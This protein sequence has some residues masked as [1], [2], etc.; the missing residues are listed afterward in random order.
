MKRT[1]KIASMAVAAMMLLSTPASAQFGGLLKKAK[2]SLGVSVGSDS[3]DDDSS[4][5]ESSVSIP[6]S[7]KKLDKEAFIYQP[8]DDPVNA[9]FYDINN[10]KVKEVYD[11]WCALDNRRVQNPSVKYWLFE[12]TDYQS[13]EKGL[14]Q[15]HVTEFP[16]TAY[17]SYA[18]MHP[19][20]V[21]GVR[22]YARAIDSYELLTMS[23]QVETL[24]FKQYKTGWGL[25]YPESDNMRKITLKDGTT[26]SL[27]ETEKA[28][29]A[30]WKELHYDAKEIIEEFTPYEV[31]KEAMKESMAEGK[32]AMQEGRIADAYNLIFREYKRLQNLIDKDKFYSVRSKDDD[33]QDLGD[34][35]KSMDHQYRLN[36]LDIIESSF[37]GT[38]EMPKEAAVSADIKQQATAQAKAK[39]GAQFVKAIVVESDWHVYTDPNNFNRTSHRS[40]GVDVIIKDG[41]DYFVSHQDLRQNF[42]A[43]SWG[44]YDMRQKDSF[45]QKV[46][47]K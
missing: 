10:P 2:K 13:P 3:S 24:P 47:Y 31:I 23:V 45:K 28:R 7:L 44:S 26:I 21:L 1:L 27:L 6:K 18:M 12:F 29:A 38:A 20:E 9:P 19:K 17:F 22:C 40:I 25:E 4:S 41:N 36:W 35:Y 11:R 16:L 37:A 14:K 39:F 34:E 33:Y 46:N 32:K 30:R 42:Q 5:S 15:V 43:G 8:T